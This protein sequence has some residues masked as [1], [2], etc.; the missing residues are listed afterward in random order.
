MDTLQKRK[1]MVAV[2]TVMLTM[3]FMGTMAFSTGTD[4]FSAAG[5]AAT[6][7][8]SAFFDLATKLLPLVIIIDAVFMLVSTDEKAI[9]T[10]KKL[11][12]GCIVAYVIIILA[13]NGA[14]MNTITNWFGTGTTGGT[15]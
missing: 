4:V 8:Q 3:A 5:E 6:S 11:L 14:I 9:A 1:N 2:I 10:G 7:A 12:I 13:N 15:T